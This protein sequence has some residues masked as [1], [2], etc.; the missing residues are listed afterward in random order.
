MN[1]I[2]RIGIHAALALV[3]PG[4]SALAVAQTYARGELVWTSTMATLMMNN[5]T[6]C[7]NGAIQVDLAALRIRF[8]N[9]TQATVRMRLNA[10]ML[11]PMAG[12]FTAMVNNDR[13]SLAIYLGNFIGVPSAAAA[14]TALNALTATVGSTGST[15][16]TIS[17]LGRSPLAF[18]MVSGFVFSGANAGDF[19]RMSVGTGC[20]M[21]TIN[22]GANCQETIRFTPPA[23]ATGTR[24]ATL[25][26]THNGSPTT[27]VLAL[28]GT[29]GTSPGGIGIPGG[30]GGGGGGA[31][32]PLA[33]LLLAAAALRRRRLHQQLSKEKFAA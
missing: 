16:L 18:A 1:C 7:H 24:T 30:G 33:L 15:T 3:L 5:C 12:L 21:Q 29:V 22:A 9:E 17:N 13:E 27:T 11:G 19:S 32:W 20:D 14:P 4:L 6:S 26:I 23:G 25:T 28:S 8:A 2:K 31:V 10:A